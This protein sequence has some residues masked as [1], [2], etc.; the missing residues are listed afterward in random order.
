M[1]FVVLLFA[2]VALPAEAADRIRAGQWVGTWTGGGRTRPTSNCI[3][4]SDA[5][6]MNG[7][8]TSIRA[9]LEK[10]IPPEICKLSDLKVNGSQITYTSLCTGGKPNIITTTYHGDSF[11]S[12]D[13]SAAKSEAKRVGA[14]K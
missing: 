2:S 3:T 7:D 11:E 13:S 4:P 12:L 8:A 1:L 5:D 6:A 10:T 9:Y 14:C